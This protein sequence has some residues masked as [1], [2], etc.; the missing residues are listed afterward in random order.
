MGGVV[1]GSIFVVKLGM[2]SISVGGTSGRSR[3][4]R[5]E[6]LETERSDDC[7]VVL[8]C[9]DQDF[10]VVEMNRP[11]LF[12]TRVDVECLDILDTH[13]ED[14]TSVQF[15]ALI[16]LVYHINKYMRNKNFG[17]RMV[18]SLN[19]SSFVCC[20]KNIVQI[21]IAMECTST[22]FLDALAYVLNLAANDWIDFNGQDKGN[23][24]ICSIKQCQIIAMG[25]I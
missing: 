16:E 19:L 10:L 8:G 2:F 9:E 21:S 11:S 23:G 22:R 14:A 24:V 12:K 15:E 7:N 5:A 13:N 6:L 1:F 20:M 18:S 3:G 25:I 17:Y 4:E